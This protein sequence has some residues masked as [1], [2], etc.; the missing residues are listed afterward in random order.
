MRYVF[1]HAPAEALPFVLF[2][3]SGGTIPLPIL[4]VQVLAI[5]LSTDT[6]PALALG[7]E[8]AEPG[9]MRR[10][11]RPRESGIIQQS[12]LARAWLRM[13]LVEAALA[14]LG[15]F[16][17]LIAAGWSPGDPT[18]SGHPLHHPYLQATTMTWAGIVA[19]QVGAAIAT[20]TTHA[21]L[22]QIGS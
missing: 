9:I 4:P 22:R 12:M 7:R 10:A 20:R 14:L 16:V 19:G 18:G 5:D 6:V 1:T 13:G 11:P 3:A 17:V 21:S 15:F 2:A 8:A